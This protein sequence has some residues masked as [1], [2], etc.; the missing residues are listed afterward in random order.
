MKRN[1]Q[2]TMTGRQKPKKPTK[3]KKLVA[4]ASLADR[5]M[6]LLR[7]RARLSDVESLRTNQ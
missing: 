4:G 6:E 2:S 3:L 7:L 1:S 5:Y